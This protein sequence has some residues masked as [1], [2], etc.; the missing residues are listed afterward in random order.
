MKDK[1]V[2]VYKINVG[3]KSPQAA[4]EAIAELMANYSVTLSDTEVQNIWL[5][6][7]DSDSTVECIYSVPGMSD[8]TITKLI[9]AI[10]F[11]KTRDVK[12]PSRGTPQSAG[13]DFFIP[14]DFNGGL[15]KF[16]RPNQN[17]LIPSGIK[18]NVPE[19]Y[20]LIA[21]NKSGVATKK[22]LYV[23]ACV[24]DEDY[25]GEVHIHVTNVGQ[26]DVEIAPGDKIM[27]FILIPVLYAKPIEVPI[28]ELYESD[29]ERGAGGFGS[30][31]NK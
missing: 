3:G 20:A 31:D 27:Q 6:V 30:T 2:F 23:G 21:F 15:P 22:N 7:K 8:S 10:K 4:K 18:V 28:D 11:S 19:G 29:T 12:S 1:A 9:P 16:L 26:E 17:A 13:I 25:Q 14:Q 5:P 24:V